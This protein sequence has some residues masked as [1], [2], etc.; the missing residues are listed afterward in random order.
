M[1]PIGESNYA[2]VIAADNGGRLGVP[3]IGPNLPLIKGDA[4]GGE[5][6]DIFG[7]SD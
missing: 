7:L 3:K 4:G 1:T 5:N 6:D 2:L